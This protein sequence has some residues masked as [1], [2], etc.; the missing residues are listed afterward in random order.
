M[1]KKTKLFFKIP[2][3]FPLTE[4]FKSVKKKKKVDLQCKM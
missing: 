3:A 2:K 1:K 4:R